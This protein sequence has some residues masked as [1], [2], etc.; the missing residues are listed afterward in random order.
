MQR[1]SALDRLLRL[2]SGVGEGGAAEPGDGAVVGEPVSAARVLALDAL[3]V[4]RR[5]V[6][7]RRA[8]RSFRRIGNAG[9]AGRRYIRASGLGSRLRDGARDSVLPELVAPSSNAE[10]AVS[11]GAG[12]SCRDVR[13]DLDQVVAE[14]IANVRFEKWLQDRLYDARIAEAKRAEI[15]ARSA[16]DCDCASCR[17]E[18]DSGRWVRRSHALAGLGLPGP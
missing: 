6:L 3:E 10:S 17:A 9:E 4:D 16:P 1:I 2:S 8:D 13:R 12:A 7:V 14:Q 11:D 18:F 15:S 5:R